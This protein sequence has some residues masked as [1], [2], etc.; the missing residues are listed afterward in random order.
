MFTSTADSVMAHSQ[1]IAEIG[2]QSKRQA[3]LTSYVDDFRYMALACF[4]CV[5]MVW[6]WKRTQKSGADVPVP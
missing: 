4:C 1:A 2:R 5:P 6:L 3:E